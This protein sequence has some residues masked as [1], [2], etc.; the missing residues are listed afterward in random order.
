MPRILPEGV[1][2]EFDCASWDAVP[3]FAYIKK[4]ADI[5]TKEMFSTF[6]M[7]IGMMMVMSAG[8]AEKAMKLLSDS[9]EKAYMI[10][11][12]VKEEGQG[13]VILK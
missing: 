11:K 6:N 1:A 8:E 3:I 12:I 5:E 4:C 10:G 9:G 2:A 7:G 13:K